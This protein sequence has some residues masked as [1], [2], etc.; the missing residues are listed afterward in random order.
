MTLFFDQG[1]VQH[2]NLELHI[3]WLSTSASEIQEN[4]TDESKLRACIHFPT[5]SEVTHDINYLAA[6]RFHWSK[7]TNTTSRYYAT[8]GPGSQ[9]SHWKALTP[10]YDNDI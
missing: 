9:G 7:P 3:Q 10:S 6:R 1:M 4:K 5:E 2:V 8:W